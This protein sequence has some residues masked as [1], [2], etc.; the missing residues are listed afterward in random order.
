MRRH[1]FNVGV[2]AIASMGF[3]FF[4]ETVQATVISSSTQATVGYEWANVSVVAAWTTAQGAAPINTSTDLVL[5][6][7]SNMSYTGTQES[8]T[9]IANMNDGKMVG[10]YNGGTGLLGDI[11]SYAAPDVGGVLTL[12]LDGKYDISRIDSFTAQVGYRNGQKYTL[13]FSTDSGA[14]WG[15]STLIN[16]NQQDDPTWAL[17]RI[18]LT[19]DTS[20][21]IATGVNAVRFTFDNPMLLTYQGGPYNTAIYSCYAEIAMYGTASSGPAAP[22]PGTLVL[23]GTGLIGLLCYAWRKRK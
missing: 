2:L 22:E 8:S 11:G 19:D 13:A 14:T 9:D 18:S 4:V 17:R 12:T 1:L 23:L 3:A 20:P 10:A 7:L 5:N 21:T 6:H 16:Y 15:A